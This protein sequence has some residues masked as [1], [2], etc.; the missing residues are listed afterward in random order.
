MERRMRMVERE[1]V[2]LRSMVE[3][4]LDRAYQIER[5]AQHRRSGDRQS[6]DR[7]SKTPSGVR[8][9]RTELSS[10]LPKSTSDQIN[11]K[12]SAQESDGRSR[13]NSASRGAMTERD[14][15]ADARWDSVSISSE[16]PTVKSGGATGSN[17][18]LTLDS[19]GFLRAPDRT[20]AASISDFV[21]DSKTEPGLR[22]QSRGS[23]Q[24]SSSRPG[25]RKSKPLTQ[26]ELRSLQAKHQIEELLDAFNK[27]N[28]LV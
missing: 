23:S 15:A 16:P 10:Y 8:S 27:K 4:L 3:E 7:L 12:R 11:G 26:R 22:G 17:L 28:G 24:R 13:E 19:L 6:R 5:H 14:H 2:E 25:S 9:S 21:D 18:S 20:D 1:N